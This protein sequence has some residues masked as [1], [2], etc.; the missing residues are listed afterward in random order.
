MSQFISELNFSDTYG[1]LQERTKR[2]LLQE[3]IQLEEFGGDV[4]CIE[5]SATKG[6][7]LP[8]LVEAILVQV[9]YY[10]KP[11]CIPSN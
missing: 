9:Y 7:N 3:A 8:E 10:L 2:M 11:Y 6:T 5:I 4:Q 1:Y